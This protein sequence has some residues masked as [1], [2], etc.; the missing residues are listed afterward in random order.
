ME[1]FGEVLAGTGQP[2]VIAYETGGLAPGQVATERDGH[3]PAPAHIGGG[4]PLPGRGASDDPVHG[5]TADP[6]TLTK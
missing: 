1:T 4:L 6:M 5:T 2:L 3:G